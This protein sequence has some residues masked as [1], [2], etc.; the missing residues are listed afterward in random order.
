M[1][2]RPTAPWVP[3]PAINALS[4]VSI[5]MA[6][7]AVDT[8]RVAYDRVAHRSEPQPMPGPTGES[9]TLSLHP[10]GVGQVEMIF[11]GGMSPDF[12]NDADAR[13]H[14]AHLKTLLDKVNVEDRGCTEKVFR[15]ANAGVA[16]AGHLSH[17]ERPNYDFAQYLAEKTGG[18]PRKVPT[19]V[20]AE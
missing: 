1:L 20:A 3:L 15:G 4:G 18:F 16:K 2:I 9:N 10:R 14:F 19:R 8:V 17:L 7:G 5:G 11:G 12:V 6:I 13:S